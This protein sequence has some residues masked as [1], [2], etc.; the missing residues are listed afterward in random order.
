MTSD[1]M[2]QISNQNDVLT[3]KSHV[4]KITTSSTV[5]LL[6]FKN[7]LKLFLSDVPAESLY[8]FELT[9]AHSA[10]RCSSIFISQ[11][12]YHTTV[13]FKIFISRYSMARLEHTT[14]VVRIRSEVSLATWLTTASMWNRIL[15]ATIRLVCSMHSRSGD[16]CGDRFGTR[17]LE[18]CI[19]LS[20]RFCHD[21]NELEM[22][23]GW[24]SNASFA[25]AFMRELE[26]PIP[27]HAR[28]NYNGLL[29]R[30]AALF[31]SPS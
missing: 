17:R 2:N 7:L 29:F 26:N 31:A 20:C 30:S 6:T 5:K 16:A 8:L 14:D 3:D 19:G 4:G 12:S 22:F 1:D 28:G 13:S 10:F 15:N 27:H 18:N 24:T 21:H 25:A 23:L 11:F 9:L